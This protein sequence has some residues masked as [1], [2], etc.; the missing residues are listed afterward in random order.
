MKI[1]SMGYMWPP[2]FVS[3]ELTEL[4]KEMQLN[5]AIYSN[6][7]TSRYKHTHGTASPS[8]SPSPYISLARHVIIEGRGEGV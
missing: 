1:E 3:V 4:L 7:N 5:G 6:M 8:P 2:L